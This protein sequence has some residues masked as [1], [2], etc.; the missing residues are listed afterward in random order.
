MKN[1]SPVYF[2][3]AFVP[4]KTFMRCDKFPRWREILIFVYV[5]PYAPE[6]GMSKHFG[7]KRGAL[8][9]FATPTVLRE[10]VS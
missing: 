2:Y 5:S 3:S 8:N 6:K 1:I 7:T 10:H 4:Y 9:V